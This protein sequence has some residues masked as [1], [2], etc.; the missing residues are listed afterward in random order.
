M[1]DDGTYWF[2]ARRVGWGWGLPCCWQGWA[3]FV[4]WLQVLFGAAATLIPRRPLAF[5]AILAAMSALHVFVCF[6]K[7]EPPPYP[8]GPG[9]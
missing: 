1:K 9:R 3:Y 7:G 4:P 5:V 8:R 2:R 6:T